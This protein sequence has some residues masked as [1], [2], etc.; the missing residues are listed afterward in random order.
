[1]TISTRCAICKTT[2][3]KRAVAAM[4]NSG[5]TAVSISEVLGGSPSSKTILAHLKDHVAGG[6]ARDV[7]V[8]PEL[9]VRE[10]VLALQ[11]LQLDEIERR[12]ELAKA[13]AVEL[14]EALDKAEE[15]GVEGADTYPRHDWSEFHDIL[16]KDMQSAIGSILKT[17]ALTDRRDKVTGELKL[18]LFE[19]MT[20]AGL[21]PVAIS[22]GKVKQLMPPVENDDD[23]LAEALYPDDIG[24]K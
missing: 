1:M 8:Q 12:I 19:A 13:R 4:W 2:D 3:Q 9:P 22:G 20:A 6:N 16:G 18:G 11:R 17:Q 7:E 23:A 14:N 15:A 21:A 5:M 10:R 24:A